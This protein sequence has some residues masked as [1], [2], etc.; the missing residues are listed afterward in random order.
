MLKLPVKFCPPIVIPAIL[1]PAGIHQ[2]RNRIKIRQA[3]LINFN[4][5]KILNKYRSY[6]MAMYWKS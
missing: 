1:I 3:I 4:K 2:P 6:E 5:V